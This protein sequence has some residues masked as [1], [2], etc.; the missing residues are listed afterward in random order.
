MGAGE[1]ITSKTTNTTEDTFQPCGVFTGIPTTI[2]IEYYSIL[3]L[4]YY[5]ILKL[6]YYSI[7]KLVNHQGWGNQHFNSQAAYVTVVLF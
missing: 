4:G 6:G 1:R 3:K 2:S 7:L 5:S